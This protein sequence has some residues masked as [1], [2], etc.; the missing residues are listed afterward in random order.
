MAATGILLVGF[1]IMHLLGNLN[2]YRGANGE[3]FVAYAEG[4]HSFGALL[5]VAEVGLVLLFGTHIWVAVRLTQTNVAARP[6][7]YAV[8][9]TFGESSVASRSMFVTGSIVLGFIVLHL[10][11]FRFARGIAPPH[12][13]DLRD[14]VFSVMSQPVFAVAYLVGSVAVGI[15]VSHG[16]KSLFQS[17]GVHHTKLNLLFYR[18]A[19]ALAV[20]IAAGFASFPL[21][22][23]FIWKGAQG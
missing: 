15:H 10:I 6:I 3:K 19:L 5:Y 20:L 13:H 4:L 1:L 2:L 9:H 21:V 12:A 11:N 23:L 22:G 16:F 18:A 7:P 14:L 8:K 17:L